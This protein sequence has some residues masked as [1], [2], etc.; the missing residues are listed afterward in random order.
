MKELL[1]RENFFENKAIIQ[2]ERMDNGEIYMNYFLKLICMASD[3]E[4]KLLFS[5]PRMLAKVTKTSVDTA[6]VATQLFERVGLLKRL[7]SG[8]LQLPV[9]DGHLQIFGEDD[10]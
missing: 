9:V 5:D 10:E 8:E 3:D 4:G 1:I 2:I 7:D 6:I